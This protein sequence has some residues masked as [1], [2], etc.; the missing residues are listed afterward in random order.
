VIW[1][2]SKLDDITFSREVADS[3][4]AFSQDNKWFVE[5]IK[6]IISQ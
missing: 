2:A 6:K 4:G 3:M 1:D 5:N